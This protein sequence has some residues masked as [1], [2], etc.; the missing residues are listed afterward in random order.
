M[1]F[2]EGIIICLPRGR[3]F[4]FTRAAVPAVGGSSGLQ[5]EVGPW[6]EHHRCQNITRGRQEASGVR[7]LCVCRTPTGQK[8]FLCGRHRWMLH[9]HN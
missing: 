4:L 8:G 2:W 6:P 7:G 5:G 3:G 9:A 1:F